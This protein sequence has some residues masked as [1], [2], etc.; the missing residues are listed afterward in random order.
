[1]NKNLIETTK[2]KL[3]TRANG[4]KMF[5]NNDVCELGGPAAPYEGIFG[6]ENGILGL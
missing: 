2:E 1:M 4:R 6:P 3:E 5:R